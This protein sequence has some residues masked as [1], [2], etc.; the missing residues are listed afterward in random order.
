MGDAIAD[1]PW[2]IFAMGTSF[3]RLQAKLH[4][5][6]APDELRASAPGYWLQRGDAVD[7]PVSKTLPTTPTCDSLVHLDFHPLNVVVDR[8]NI[9]GLV[10]W[11]NAAAGDPRADVARTIVLLRLA[12]IPPHPMKAA[13][14]VARSLLYLSWRRGYVRQAGALPDTAPYMTWAGVT[15]LKDMEP[16]LNQAGVWAD[17]RDVERI[18]RWVERTAHGMP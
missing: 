10:D 12:P 3:G 18:R 8:G 9:T 4:T 7:F 11:T 13:L 14:Q 6:R 15:L 17:Q 1:A 2:R 16:R 5:V